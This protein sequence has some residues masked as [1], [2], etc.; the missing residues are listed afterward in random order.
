MFLRIKTNGK[1][2]DKVSFI[3]GKNPNRLFASNERAVKH[4][5]AVDVTEDGVVDFSK[6][7]TSNFPT[8]TIE[9]LV[10]DGI[11]DA[12]HNVLSVEDNKKATYLVSGNELIRRG[13]QSTINSY[14]YYKE[15][16]EEQV[17]VV[18]YS[19]P[20][21]LTFSQDFQGYVN[22]KEYLVTS[23]FQG[24]I[25]NV[26]RDALNKEGNFYDNIYKT[27]IEFGPFKFKLQKE[28][29]IQMFEEL[30]FEVEIELCN[31]PISFDNRRQE[32]GFIT[33]RKT[34]TI[35]EALRQAYVLISAIDNFRHYVPKEQDLVKLKKFTTGWLEN[36]SMN[37]L[38]TQ[39]YMSYSTYG[40]DYLNEIK[41]ANPDEQENKGEKIEA[42]GFGENGMKL[43]E[44]RLEVV[45]DAVVGVGAKYVVDFGCGEGNLLM[46]LGFIPGLKVIGVDS[47]VRAF[48]N[49]Q[50]RMKKVTNPEFVKPQIYQSSLFF[51]DSRLIGADTVVLCEVVEHNEKERLPLIFEN[52]MAINP[53]NL[54]VSTP[55]KE[56]NKYLGTEGEFRHYDHR[57]EFTEAEYKEFCDTL[58][59]KYSFTYELSSFGKEIDGI[60]PTMI[61]VFKK[62]GE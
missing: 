49:A 33:L 2:A 21:T 29:I 37:K 56:Y 8:E 5:G 13:K 17:E 62:R 19:V 50:R 11:I 51:K 30:G 52:V 15:Y 46:K 32:V 43:N 61:A 40:N 34:S 28:K 9:K 27:E 14:F 3:Y 39:R 44:Q 48:G 16:A 57:F 24:E 53:T 41:T 23:V 47:S 36:H 38:I 55:N 12:E 18:L 58:A 6:V 59:D 1:D 31:E 42:S 26:L 35:R 25:G 60:R 20:D 4:N 54:I 7:Q 45:K 22:E 10:K